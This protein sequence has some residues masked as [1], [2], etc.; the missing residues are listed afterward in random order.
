M[1]RLIA[2]LT[3]SLLTFSGVFATG[4]EIEQTFWDVDPNHIYFDAVEWMHG[5]EIVKGYMDDGF[6]PDE[7]V[8]RAEALKM[9]LA[10]I[11]APSGNSEAEEDTSPFEDVHNSDWYFDFVLAGLH[12]GL[13]KGK[14]DGL[15]HPDAQV[16]RAEAVKML[17][18]AS[19][20]FETPIDESQY[21]NWYEPYMH[22]AQEGAWLTP[23]AN[24]DYLPGKALTRAELAMLIHRME[25]GGFTGSVEYGVASYYGWS[26]DGRTTA[27]GIPLDAYSFVAAHKSLPFGTIVRVTN[28][29][30]DRYV[31]VE[32]VDRGP[33]VA[34]RIIDLTPAA[35]EEI[36]WLSSG[37]LN[38]RVE[39]M[40]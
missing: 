25:H 24:G 11:P 17:V 1:K 20:D 4:D 30:N 13:V 5:Q 37:V 23:D 27:S 3:L 10:Y 18:L 15:F 40:N 14:S 35:F 7:D 36:G 33:F 26:F 39:V 38:V 22:Y 8:S 32:I 6:H 21:N 28:V 29:N 12:R 34:G 16:N 19:M 2:A 9:I 31:D